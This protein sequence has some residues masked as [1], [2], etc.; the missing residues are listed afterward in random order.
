MGI[1][2]KAQE[3]IQEYES[4]ISVQEL[5]QKATDGIKR[6]TVDRLR[7]EV[8]S[9]DL[10][11]LVSL[12]SGNLN[13]LSDKSKE[14]VIHLSHLANVQLSRVGEGTHDITPRFK[15][16]ARRSLSGGAAITRQ[17]DDSEPLPGMRHKSPPPD[18]PQTH[19]VTGRGCPTKQAHHA[20]M[21]HQEA[22][23]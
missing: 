23:E 2:E 18:L 11:T 6:L 14:M 1:S 20:L 7:E 4:D 12:N 22:L 15:D 8:V 5:L 9:K 19:L 17:P 3:R 13:T 10:R 21:Q 16:S